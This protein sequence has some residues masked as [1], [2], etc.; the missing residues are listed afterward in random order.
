MCSYSTASAPAKPPCP[1]SP[2]QPLLLL[3]DSPLRTRERRDG[4]Q[5]RERETARGRERERESERARKRE[6]G[7]VLQHALLPK[8]ATAYTSRMGR[9][10]VLKQ[11]HADRGRTHAH[12]HDADTL[13]N[14][15][16]IV[17]V[18]VQ[19]LESFGPFTLRF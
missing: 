3:N 1:T 2:L 14:S 16:S 17:L 10:E 5:E 7:A 15:P 9:A 11:Q 18:V 6:S 19:S 13:R 4:A 8:P 12:P